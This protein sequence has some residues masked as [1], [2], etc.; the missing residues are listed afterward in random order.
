MHQIARCIDQANRTRPAVGFRFS[1]RF[2]RDEPPA[3]RDH[4]SA[5]RLMRPAAH[6]MVPPE[7]SRGVACFDARS[8][9]R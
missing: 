3:A 2:L 9:Q 4:P 6:E 7:N 8:F 1:F 5:R